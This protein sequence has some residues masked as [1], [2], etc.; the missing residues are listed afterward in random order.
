MNGFHPFDKVRQLGDRL[1]KQHFFRPAAPPSL[2][3]FRFLYC[4]AIICSLA[5]ARAMHLSKFADSPWNPIPLFELLGIGLMSPDAYQVLYAVLIAALALTAV[6]AAT[7][8]SATV[9]WI[10][11][12]LYLGTFLGFNKSPHVSY[13]I[14][15]HNMV[16]VVLLILSL[17]PGVA[18]FGLDGWLVRRFRR[19]RG[20]LVPASAWPSQ[21]IK[22]TLG[23]AYFGA[24]YCKMAGNPL[25]ADGTT[26]QSYLM[27]KYLVL[28]CEPGHWVA[29]SWWLCL[30]LGIATL[31]LE[32]TFFLIVFYPRLTWYY[33]LA[34]IGF[35]AG[36]HLTM[37]INFFPYYGCALLIFLDWSTLQA[38][39]RMP[40]RLAAWLAAAVG[41]AAPAT[42]AAAPPAAS[43]IGMH[44]IVGDT[45]YA[46]AIVL[47]LWGLLLFCIYARVESWPLTDYGVFAGRSKLSDVHIYRL[48]AIDAGGQMSWVGP[49]WT[50][51]SPTWFHRYVNARLREDDEASLAR[52]LD[53]L[54]PHVARRDQTGALR[55]IAI[56]ERTLDTDPQTGR[57][58]IIDRPRGQVSLAGCATRPIVE[59]ARRDDLTDDR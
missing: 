27:S 40:R 30:A 48:A 21:L 8:I 17:A 35:H 5:A 56:V 26:L 55:S 12:F 51:L 14:H 58:L 4:A 29:Q 13:V 7:R 32:L 11:F 52:L 3:L 20:E 2:S 59:F 54:A 39:A 50:P 41:R 49:D 44:P 38:L 16:V 37:G 1:L 10:A 45:R 6:G 15:S 43:T 46:R 18:D 23:L 19:S 36:I 57:L 31:T 42:F 28:D 22:L 53:D 9:A 25:W 24:G 47:G 33:V 34:A